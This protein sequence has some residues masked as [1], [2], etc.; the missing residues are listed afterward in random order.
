MIHTCKDHIFKTT[1]IKTFL[2]WYD[3][4]GYKLLLHHDNVKSGKL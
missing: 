4:N 1:V 3:E 2:S